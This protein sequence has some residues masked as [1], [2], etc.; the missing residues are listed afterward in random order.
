MKQIVAIIGDRHCSPDESKARIAFDMGCALV[1]NGYRVLTG[2]MGGKETD[3]GVM[4]FAMKGARFSNRYSEGDTIAVIPGFSPEQASRYADIVIPTGLDVYRNCITANADAV[5]AIG[6]GAGTLCE[7]AFAWSLGRLLIGFNN[8]KGW[9]SLLAGK[10]IDQ[11]KRY[12]DAPTD[13]VY[14]VDSVDYAIQLLQ[15]KILLYNKRH[16]SIR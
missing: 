13:C 12:A 3:D 6:G 7:M 8:V 10:P 2:G 15:E 11:R 5:I 14:S 16:K 9:S 1:D 4:D